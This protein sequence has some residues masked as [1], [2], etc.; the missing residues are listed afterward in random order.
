[1]TDAYGWM[2][3]DGCVICP[4]CEDW[5]TVEA[6]GN[7]AEMLDTIE[8]HNCSGISPVDELELGGEG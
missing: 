7:I 6:D 2:Y 3:C 8:S 1:M 4:V 5:I